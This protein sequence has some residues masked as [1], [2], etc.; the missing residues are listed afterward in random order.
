M[1]RRKRAANLRDSL[2]RRTRWQSLFDGEVQ[3]E[4]LGSKDREWNSPRFLDDLNAQAP[5]LGFSFLA[6]PAA[7]QA[8]V[9]D[10]AGATVVP[11]AGQDFIQN[12]VS[13]SPATAG[14]AG[15][16]IW[17]TY[18]AVPRG[19]GRRRPRRSRG[20]RRRVAMRELW[21]RAS[22]P[23]D[24]APEVE[25]VEKI[26]EKEKIVVKEVVVEKII[27]KFVEGEKDRRS[28]A[29]DRIPV[30]SWKCSNCKNCN[31]S[32]S[33][34][35]AADPLP[36]SSKGG[37][38]SALVLARKFLD[39]DRSSIAV[40]AAA[41]YESEHSSVRQKL[42]LR[43]LLQA[44]ADLGRWVHPL[45]MEGILDDLRPDDIDYDELL[46]DDSW[47]DQSI[48]LVGNDTVIG[49]VLRDPT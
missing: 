34:P 3:E 28:A 2:W 22:V 25:Y 46:A 6:V 43:S 39:R 10:I 24:V 9:R 13:L 32:G 40:R 1:Q 14:A 20:D 47:L 11:A 4:F 45:D 19:P 12:R 17:D 18:R 26:V 41:I 21:L 30:A 15:L 16:S 31:L 29:E 33:R 5:E 23:A 38:A 35:C 42:S 7:G 36:G 48:C 49:G 37:Y 44:A 27:E 8:P